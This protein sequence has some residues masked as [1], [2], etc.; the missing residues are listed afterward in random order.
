[1]TSILRH[2][3]KLKD[4]KDAKGAV[5][6]NSLF[7]PL[8]WRKNPVG[9]CKAGRL[10]AALLNGNDKQ[11]FYADVYLANSWFPKRDYFLWT[12]FIGC[13]QGHSTGLIAPA[14][15]T[16]ALSSVECFAL[17]WIFHTTD[18]RF[19][20]SIEENGLVGRGRDAFGRGRDAL[21]FMY[22]DDGGKGYIRKGA[23]TKEP[24]AYS[25]TIYVVMNVPMMLHYKYELFLTG[26][27]VVLVFHDLP[28]QCFRFNDTF[29]HLS[30][31]IFNPT[32]GHTLP[33]QFN[34]DNGE[35]T[36]KHCTSTGNT[37]RQMRYPSTW[38][39]LEE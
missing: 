10:F 5:P 19:Q 8:W 31:N 4:E 17:G 29:P 24:R 22:E 6:L 23:G 13:H 34:M 2:K 28:I 20:K 36:S 38:M 39:Q 35:R 32:T 33:R 11:R 37:C 26:N 16:H 12:V 18:S 14:T 15:V 3:T 9:Q 21:H 30:I 25:S 7:G 27:G 1:M